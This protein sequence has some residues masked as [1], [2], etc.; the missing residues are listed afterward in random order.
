MTDSPAAIPGGGS[1]EQIVLRQTGRR[2]PADT[3]AV[4]NR[5][6]GSRS[7]EGA[8]ARAKGESLPPDLAAM[9][10]SAFHLEATSQRRGTA[11]G[12][13]GAVAAGAVASRAAA[14]GVQRFT[15]WGPAPRPS[16]SGNSHIFGA[17]GHLQVGGP[18]GGDGGGP[19][20]QSWRGNT[21]EEMKASLV[22]MLAAAS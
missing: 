10:T 17:G 9:Q 7:R 3:A 4:I 15:P 16:P 21:H 5:P 12:G 13:R 20:F 11:F 8:A 2:L 19:A 14:V 6:K 1:I 18:R 22:R